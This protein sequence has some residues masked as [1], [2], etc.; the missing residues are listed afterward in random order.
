MD[1]L[2]LFLFE[3]YLTIIYKFLIGIDFINTVELRI[4]N[5]NVS[6]IPLEEI[7]KIKQED[8][9]EIFQINLECEKTDEVDMT[10]ITD[11]KLL[12]S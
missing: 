9:P 5:G 1:I 8:L 10:H 12:S 11:D 7:I 6:I 4:K 2:I 3:L